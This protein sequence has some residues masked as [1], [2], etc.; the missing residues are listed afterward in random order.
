MC[1]NN[2][3]IPDSIRRDIDEIIASMPKRLQDDSPVLYLRLLLSKV[4]DH[5]VDSGA[6]HGKWFESFC[7]V[8]IQL[9]YNLLSHVKKALKP[10]LMLVE[11]LQQQIVLKSISDFRGQEEIRKKSVEKVNGHLNKP[12]KWNPNVLFGRAFIVADEDNNSYT[13]FCPVD[14]TS[15]RYDEYQI[16]FWN[17]LEAHTK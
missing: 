10:K 6:T 3:E 16:R 4:Q 15:G 9:V 14:Q 17:K 8:E 5:R 7:T 12:R 1:I 2:L 11:S 13:I